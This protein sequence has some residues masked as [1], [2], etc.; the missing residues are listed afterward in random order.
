MQPMI[1]KM[2]MIL[3]VRMNAR[4]MMRMIMITLRTNYYPKTTR[5]ELK[6]EVSSRT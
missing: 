3:V 1:T 5:M 6:I 4:R 2:K